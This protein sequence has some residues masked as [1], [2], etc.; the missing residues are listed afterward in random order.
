M[1]DL[2]LFVQLPQL[3]NLVTGEHENLYLAAAYLEWAV[4]RSP[5][6]ADLETAR[7]PPE[8]D[9]ASDDILVK[10][11]VD[12]RPRF[13][14]CTVYLWN[15]ERTLAIMRRVK[16]ALPATTILLGGPELARA[17][18]LLARP[19]PADILVIGEGE[20]VLPAFLQGL[21]GGALP[22]FA[23]AAVRRGRSYAWGKS[24]PEEISLAREL[25]PPDWPGLAPD[26]RGMAYVETSRG[27]PMHCT[28]CRYHQLRRTLS[29][30]EPAAIAARVKALRD[31]GAREIRFVDPTFNAH[32]RFTETLRLLAD[33]NRDRR[34]A[35]FAELRADRL[36]AE[37]ADLLAAARFTDIEAGVQ[38]LEPKVL[39]AIGRPSDPLKTGDGIRRMA[40]RGIRVTMDLM[41][42]LPF[43][44]RADVDRS[45]DWA[46]GF[47]RSVN[48]QCM[49]TLLLP[50][51][52]LRRQAMRWGI[53]ADPL[54]PYA[55]LETP[56]MSRADL[57][58]V[59]D[60]LASEERL[61]TDTPTGRFVGRSLPELFPKPVIIPVPW[62][63]DAVLPAG[64]RQARQAWVF[65]GTGLFEHAP[66]LAALIGKAIRHSPHTLWQFVLE[67][68]TEEPLDLLD[69]L[70]D[71]IRSEPPMIVDRY[72]SVSLRGLIASRRL[73]IRLQRGR[74]YDPDWVRA[75]RDCL[76]A[77]FF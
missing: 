15:I 71:A 8:L 23:C 4:Q 43:Q 27:C 73:F 53:K 40:A 64:P 14:A 63:S 13:V 52:I 67:P 54:P 34:L 19:G 16:R 12:R 72:A 37:Q 20:R 33:V 31:K 65:R 75:A 69:T 3:D 2:L 56:W 62:P 32:P 66:R 45:L 26:A 36:T 1:S 42:G 49:H 38:S 74:A 55:V 10:T 11:I 5:L 18:P 39:E 48:I 44:T 77:S 76:E 70:A 21:R 41:I 6:T 29:L 22:E 35:F 28:Y 58:A 61:R 17:H 9:L 50:G 59:E 46:L 68:E 7:L 25:P 57:L 30:L 24:V 51:T 60:R 47:P